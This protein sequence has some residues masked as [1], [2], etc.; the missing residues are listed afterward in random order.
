[1]L[2][3]PSLTLQ[4]LDELLTELP[5]KSAL[6]TMLIYKKLL[7]IVSTS[8]GYRMRLEL[9]IRV[10]PPNPRIYKSQIGIYWKGKRPK[11]SWYTASKNHLLTFLASANQLIDE[12]SK[13]TDYIDR[14]TLDDMILDSLWRSFQEIS[15]TLRECDTCTRI[16]VPVDDQFI[17]WD[18]AEFFAIN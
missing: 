7:T 6:S 2:T 18:A 14:Y 1:M 11:T 9:R 8:K 4:H 15:D 12:W 17:N 13:F 16:L 10:N 3:S 5:E